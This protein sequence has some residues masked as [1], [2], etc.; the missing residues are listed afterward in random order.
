[1]SPMAS[2]NLAWIVGRSGDRAEAGK[3]AH[4]ALD[5]WREERTA[6][7]FRWTA[8]R[9]LIALALVEGQLLEAIDFARELLDI[10]QQPLPEYLAVD[11]RGAVVA[12]DSGNAATARRLLGAATERAAGNGYL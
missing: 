10:S 4:H 7:P 9:P 11:V 12:W 3:W 8:L 6:F 2:A 5:C 1:M